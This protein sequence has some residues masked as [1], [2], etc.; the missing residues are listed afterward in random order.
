ML[1]IIITITTYTTH[2]Q[3]TIFKHTSRHYEKYN[4][5]CSLIIVVITF[6]FCHNLHSILEEQGIGDGVW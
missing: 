1:I 5:A 6:I 2:A 3:H 4:S